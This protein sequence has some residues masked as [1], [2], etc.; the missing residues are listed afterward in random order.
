MPVF[1]RLFVF[2]C[3]LS[4]FPC[5]LPAMTYDPKNVF[6]RILSGEIPCK[7]LFESE[8]ALAFPDLHPQAPIHV[9]VIPKGAYVSFQDFSERATPAEQAGFIHAVGTVAKMTGAADNGYRL[10]ANAGANAHQEVP[11]FHVHILGGRAL[12]PMLSK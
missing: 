8:Y 12:G 2:F 4:G 10:I 11:H 3:T 1:A 9:L 7:K 5:T 6:A